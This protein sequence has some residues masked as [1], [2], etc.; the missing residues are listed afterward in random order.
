MDSNTDVK[1]KKEN[2]K[3]FAE[4]IK[5]RGTQGRVGTK[6]NT[7]RKRVDLICLVA[8]PNCK[9]VITENIFVFPHSDFSLYSV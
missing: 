4:G 8:V 5:K 9:K 2:I 6:G 3:G 7:G 1:M